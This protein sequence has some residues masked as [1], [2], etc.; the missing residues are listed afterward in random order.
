MRLPSKPWAFVVAVAAGGAAVLMLWLRNPSPFGA[1]DETMWA[2]VVVFGGLTLQGWIAPARLIHADRQSESIHLDEGYFVVMAL[3]LPPVMTITVFA[4]MVAVAH[5]VRRRAPIQSLF[6]IGKVLLSVAAGLAV[7]HV[8]QPPGPTLTADA[9]AAVAVGAAVYFVINSALTAWFRI[10]LGADWRSSFVDGQAARVTVGATGALVGLLLGI[11]VTG[12]PW[13][14]ALAAPVVIGL[15][16][17][18]TRQFKAMHDRARMEGLFK[19][20]LE[21]NRRLRAESVLET[22]VTS[23]R[24]VLRC[25]EARITDQPPGPDEMGTSLT[26]DGVSHWLVVSG[27]PREEPFDYADRILLDAL[28]AIGRGALTNASLY[29]QVRFEQERLSSITLSIGEG[30]CAVDAAGRLTFVNPAAAELIHLPSLSVAVG[31]PVDETALQAP[32]FLME[33]ARQAMESRKVITEDDVQ[34]PARRGGTVPVSYTAS[35]VLDHGTAVG[36]VVNFR[37][38]AE[39]K[40]YEDE[41][42]HHAHYDTLTGLPN[43]RLLVER[44]D[45]AL[46]QSA[47]DHK[48]HAL[49]FV[50][51]DRFKSINDSLG[52]VTGD[53]LLVAIAQRMRSAAGEDDLLARFGGDEFILLIEDVD[54]VADGVDAARRICAAVE[55]PMTLSD[56]YE[57]VASVSVGIAL[58]EAGKT[59]DD[60]LRDADVA[61]YEAKVKGRGGAYQVFDITAM[62]S[63]SSE[64]LKLE[65][66]L[67]K[68][69][70]REELDVYYQ[71]FFSVE[72]LRIVGAEALV[73]WRH[74]ELGL[75]KPGDFI[76]MAEETGLILPVGRYVMERACHQVR[77]IRDR[78][79]IELPMSVNLSPRQ[80]QQASLVHD[81]ALALGH[82]GLDPSV[83]TFEI[84][85]TM[86]MDDLARA[87][88]T[89]KK[90][91]RLGVR[92]AIDDF[93]TGHSSLGYL[94]QFPVHEVKVDRL[95]V[96][97]VPE[98]PVDSA[99][100]RAVVDLASAMGIVAIAE[101]VET[102][103]QLAGLK[104]LGCPVGQGY[105]F[106]PPVPAD[107][108]MQL[109]SLR[110]VPEALV[111]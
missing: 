26:V 74:P 88:E 23:A 102:A 78:L 58:T 35:P 47:L 84:T 83:L 42:L 92:L 86:V 89:M 31:D 64:R 61:M 28:A 56:G 50:D 96:Q 8:L 70:E 95:F 39:R 80:F 59:S 100:V 108:L 55:E 3:L 67:R 99:I 19:V 22:M 73:R 85:E 94:K 75:L 52:H 62:G 24:G 71:P 60:I 10:A 4:V 81:A 14:L 1:T 17:V 25:P 30:I 68:G 107:E 38:I 91:N 20:T 36:A 33:L 13:A 101:G 87:R 105:Y 65:A 29:R 106:S 76:E 66:A 27:R 9:L 53:D 48:T 21:A 72:D 110:L 104:T 15:H 46:S 5:L 54:G 82:A 77:S 51:V 12:R 57:I 44:L 18:L 90:L 6:N 43:R 37:D 63:R 7:V 97:G 98:S 69:L 34:F 45:L 79:G 2:V 103:D 49:V 93:G 41:I 111:S 109:L 32:E 40:A 11:A 16:H